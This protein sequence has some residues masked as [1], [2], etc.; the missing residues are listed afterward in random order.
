[1]RHSAVRHTTAAVC[2][3]MS[4][5]TAITITSSRPSIAHSAKAKEK[6]EKEEKG[7]SR[8][9]EN[10]CRLR[11]SAAAALPNLH[12]SPTSPAQHHHHH[13]QKKQKQKEREE[14]GVTTMRGQRDHHH[15]RS[16]R[17]QLL[18]FI[19]SALHCSLRTT[20]HTDQTLSDDTVCGAPTY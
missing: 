2:T 14:L 18:R 6:E 4:T 8:E 3:Q 13:Q 7:E 19:K 12:C 11:R 15:P 10:W 17:L 16:T 5:T 9:R 1:M 20:M